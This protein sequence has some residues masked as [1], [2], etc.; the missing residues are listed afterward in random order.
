M[1]SVRARVE[2]QHSSSGKRL[3]SDRRKLCAPSRVTLSV[4][5]NPR[6]RCVRVATSDRDQ[7][8]ISLQKDEGEATFAPLDASSSGGLGGTSSDVFGPLVR[9]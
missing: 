9:L 8:Q 7:E 1:T 2:A 6:S 3:A 4:R 5:N